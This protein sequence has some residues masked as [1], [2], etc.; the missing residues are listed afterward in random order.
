[1]VADTKKG[2]DYHEACCYLSSNFLK[3]CIYNEIL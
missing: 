1:M 3:E 2:D